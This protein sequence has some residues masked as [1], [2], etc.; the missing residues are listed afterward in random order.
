MNKPDQQRRTF[1]SHGSK[2]LGA[3]AILGAGPRLPLPPDRLSSPNRKR[4]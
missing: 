1:L 2:M 4:P 3:C